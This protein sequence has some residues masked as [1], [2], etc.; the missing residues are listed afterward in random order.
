MRE[1]N[2]KNLLGAAEPIDIAYAALFL[3]SDEARVT[4]GSIFLA[5]SGTTVS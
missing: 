4:T 3:A 5:E 2:A 1:L